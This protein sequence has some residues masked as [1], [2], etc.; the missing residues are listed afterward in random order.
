[1]AL[2]FLL[3]PNFLYEKQHIC[4]RHNIMLI[5]LVH[6]DKSTFFLIHCNYEVNAENSPNSIYLACNMP[7]KYY[8]VNN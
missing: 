5:C 6:C 7:F 3:I 8:T 2:Y 4:F 1:M